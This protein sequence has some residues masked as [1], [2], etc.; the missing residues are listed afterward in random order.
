MKKE[1]EKKVELEYPYQ[2][3]TTVGMIADV[4]RAIVGD[5]AEVLNIIGEGIDPHSYQASSGDIEQFTSAAVILYNGLHLEGKLGPILAKQSEK[6][7]VIAAAESL[8]DCDYEIIGGESESDPHVW[9]DVS[10]WIRVTEE[11]TKQLSEFDPANAE[12][13]DTNSKAYVERLV[14]LN[15]Y[16]RRCIASIPEDQRV[17]VTAHDAFSYL[18]RAYGVDV[19]GIQG[20]STESKAGLNHI[21]KLIDFLVEKKI[22]AVFVESSMPERSVKKL[23]EGAAARGHEVT[24][25][26]KLF[27]DAMGPA[28]SYEGTYIGMIDHN[29]TTITDALGGEAPDKGLHGKLSR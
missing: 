9:M 27:S 3:T 17:L 15:Q 13:Y 12:I 8:V 26:G 5:R 18:G 10:G 24:I 11:I 23:V 20:I 29:I 21:N 14:E 4:T 2:I 1:N 25:G 22:P 19:R 16:A 6:K 7:T 28:G